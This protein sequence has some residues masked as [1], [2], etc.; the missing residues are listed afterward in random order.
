MRRANEGPHP[1]RP[2]QP[3]GRTSF[4]ANSLITCKTSNESNWNDVIAWQ[5]SCIFERAVNDG[6]REGTQAAETDDPLWIG[7][8]DTLQIASLIGLDIAKPGF[9]LTSWM[10]A[11]FREDSQFVP[12]DVVAVAFCEP[13]HSPLTRLI[14]ISVACSGIIEPIDDLHP[15]RLGIGLSRLRCGPRRSLPSP[16]NQYNVELKLPRIK[17]KS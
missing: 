10:P 8:Q 1:D 14:R 3:A 11:E 9:S 6:D 12:S 15:D 16:G 2:R 5:A 7:V 4:A 17:G 13:A